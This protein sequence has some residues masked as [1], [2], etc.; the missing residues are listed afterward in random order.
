MEKAKKTANN[1]TETRLGLVA[2]S[3]NQK[4]TIIAS[5]TSAYK[6]VG[7][8]RRNFWEVTSAYETVAC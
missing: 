5:S 6:R 8:V 2:A 7:F 3:S 1:P 4:H